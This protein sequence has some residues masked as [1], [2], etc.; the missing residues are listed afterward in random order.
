MLSRLPVRSNARG[1]R[2]FRIPVI[3]GL[4]PDR[5]R[6]PKCCGMLVPYLRSSRHSE[7]RH[8][9]S[10]PPHRISE[11]QRFRDRC[12]VGG[13]ARLDHHF[14]FRG[15]HRRDGMQPLVRHL[16]D[17][18]SPVADFAGDVSQDAGPVGNL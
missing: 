7:L 12:G 3:R 2:S 16:D 11:L 13:I 5:E 8:R 10:H 14:Q 1:V 4:M 9:F 15:L 6:L 17:I 18:A